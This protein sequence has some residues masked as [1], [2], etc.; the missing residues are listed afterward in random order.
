MKKVEILKKNVNIANRNKS[1]E[2]N[3]FYNLFLCTY[4]SI[5]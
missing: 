3:Y 5:H 4:Y 1:K 2:N